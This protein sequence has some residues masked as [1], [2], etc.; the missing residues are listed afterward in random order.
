MARTVSPDADSAE[1]DESNGGRRA[2]LEARRR[3]RTRTTIVIIAIVLVLGGLG[4]AA[5]GA[6]RDDEPARAATPRTTQPALASR[7]GVTDAPAARTISFRALDHDHPLRLWVGGDSLAGSFGFSLGDL[8]D[9]TGVV[10]TTVD[11]KVSSGLASNDLR[12]WQQRT[13]EQMFLNN[14]EAVVF[15]IGA[16]DA[17]IVNKVD[18]NG[19]GVPDW[20]PIYRA[21]VDKMMD[22]MIGTTHRTVVWI[23]SPPLGDDRI[24]PGAEEL[25]KVMQQEAAKRSPD[26]VYVDAYKLFLGPD[27]NYS[28][29]ITDENGKEFTARIADGVHFT[30]DGAS[31]L[32]RAVFS[33]VDGRWHVMKQADP[34]QPIQWKLASGSGETVPGYAGTPKSKYRNRSTSNYTTPHT[35]SRNYGN[36][37]SSA[38]TVYTPPVTE[39]P[40]TQAPPVTKGTLPPVTTKTT[41]S[42]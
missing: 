33:L 21:K 40:V 37:N 23:G 1:P 34:K 38:T 30:P 7:S 15:M 28:R 20:D 3:H 31:Y 36:G 42:P 13:E 19:D 6:Y 2:R 17:M 11:Y 12:N 22:T 32:A 26:V 29:R 8:T 24:N 39:A 18:A 5:Y 4:V 10:Q 27:G 14:P 9:A 41:P 35:S 16:N 25:D